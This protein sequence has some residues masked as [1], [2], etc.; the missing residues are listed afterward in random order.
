MYVFKYSAPSI[1]SFGALSRGELY[2]ASAEE[3]NDGSEC[4]PRY[5][6]K[7]SEELWIRLADM[8]L[9]DAICKLPSPSVSAATNLRSL[10]ESLGRALQSKVGKRDL[11][12]EQLGPLVMSVLPGLLAALKHAAPRGALAPLK[13]PA[14]RH[15]A[16]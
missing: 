7:G 11:D 1:L 9:L 5:I 2:F 15:E 12:F 4:R 3:L 13:L 10:D 16:T 14:L 8:I 6:L